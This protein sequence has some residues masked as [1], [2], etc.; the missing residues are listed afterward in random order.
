MILDDLSSRGLEAIEECDV[1]FL[2][3]LQTEKGLAE[4]L[5]KYATSVKR[6]I[7]IHNTASV[8]DVGLDGS[9]G[10]FFALRPFVAENPE[11]FVAYAVRNQYGLLI[12]GC[13]PEDRPEKPIAAWPI[14]HGPGTE[15]S[16][17][18]HDIGIN[19]K[20][21]CGCRALSESMDFAGSA[22]C[23]E[24]LDKIVESITANQA[25]WS[26]RE[27]LD[28][29]FK[30]STHGYFSIESLVLEAIRRSE[31]SSTG[32]ERGSELTQPETVPPETGLEALP[33]PVLVP[34]TV[35]P[36]TVP[37]ETGADE[38]IRSVDNPEGKRRKRK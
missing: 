21:G 20:K 15:L 9:P 10:L 22:K 35:P 26:W 27:K 17:I 8:G 29:A 25:N 16:A 31:N 36:E 34:E 4:Q 14:G 12:L 7:V 33:P 37:P 32:I 6:F 11:W 30:V 28:A 5:R 18:L 24:D 1:L 3:E 2:D 23:R 38:S 19:P 13:R